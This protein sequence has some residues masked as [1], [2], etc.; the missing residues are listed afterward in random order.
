MWLLTLN[1]VSPSLESMLVSATPRITRLYCQPP[2]HAEHR[3]TRQAGTDRH[4]RKGEADGRERQAGTRG[5]GHTS[6]S[7]HSEPEKQALAWAKPSYAAHLSVGECH[8]GAAVGDD[9][10][11]G[12]QLMVQAVGVLGGG[13]GTAAGQGARSKQCDGLKKEDLNGLMIQEA[14]ADPRPLLYENVAAPPSC[15][16]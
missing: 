5:E 6:V 13:A 3:Y 11:Q 2:P 14:P 1:L 4:R 9:V 8:A 15:A 12:R 7:Q 10:L 16:W